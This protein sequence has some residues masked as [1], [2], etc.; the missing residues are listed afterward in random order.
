[1]TGAKSSWGQSEGELPS[2]PTQALLDNN[3]ADCNT[4][5][6]KDYNDHFVNLCC[7]PIFA[8]LQTVMRNHPIKS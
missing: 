7:F 1:M 8:I 3:I 5:D 2:G 4:A 6:H